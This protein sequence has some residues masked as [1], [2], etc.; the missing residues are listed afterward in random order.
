MKVNARKCLVTAA[1]LVFG[2]RAAEIIPVSNGMEAIPDSY[3]VV[4][5]DD[6]QAREFDT[7]RSWVD[8]LLHDNAA[9][10]NDAGKGWGVKYIEQDAMI[11]ALG[12]VTQKGAGW[13]LSR[14]SHKKLPPTPEYVYEER[15]GQN[16]HI[17]LLDTG[18]DGTNSG[19]RG[20]VIQGINTTPD[21]DSDEN[22]HG[23]SVAE[24]IA[25]TV[26]GVAKKALVVSVKILDNTGSGSIS[27]IIKGLDW[28]ISDVAKRNIVGKA[29]MN[30]SL[31]GAYSAS[32]NQAT[33][34]V[35]KAGIFVAASVGAGN[36]D[37]PPLFFSHSSNFW[38]QRDASQE[39]P[40]SANG[41]CAVAAST[42]ADAPASFGSYGPVVDIYA[43]GTNIT[44]R[45]HGDKL[46]TVSGSSYSTSQVSGMAT[47]I[48]DMGMSSDK[49]CETI[50]KLALPS[51]QDPK[52]GTTKLLLYNGSGL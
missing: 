6:I 35:I 16:V 36:V 28:S 52:P 17:Y 13:Y 20:R 2:V 47:F 48:I 4:M 30:M 39:S 29:V 40:V 12:L 9:G 7:H 37:Y 21:G 43:P 3:L 51:I 44:T 32:F 10:A 1:L 18:V 41:V 38:F 8:G 26:H 23:T 27:G 24:V 5:K 45:I 50:K 34:K 46:V 42:P 11:R 31:G 19:L 22:G 14:I 49:V 15:A 25:G 33:E